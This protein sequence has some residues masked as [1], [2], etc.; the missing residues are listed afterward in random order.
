MGKIINI[1]FSGNFQTYFK[2]EKDFFMKAS[3]FGRY[4]TL[5][6]NIKTS[7]KQKVINVI[8]KELDREKDSDFIYEIED[9]FGQYGGILLSSIVVNVNKIN[10]MTLEKRDDFLV[11]M[12]NDLLKKIFQKFP[13]YT[14]VNQFNYENGMQIIKTKVPEMMNKV[15]WNS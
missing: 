1:G 14:S 10:E 5:F 9:K 15:D 7:D 4:Y 6:L 8:M 12:V 11:N 13:T 2:E 3:F